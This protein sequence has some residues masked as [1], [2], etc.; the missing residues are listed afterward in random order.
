MAKRRRDYAKETAYES[1]P[2]QKK[3]RAERNHD[4]RAAERAGLVHKG[5]G[6][7]VDHLGSHRTGNLKGVPTKV[8]SKHANRIR[9]PKRS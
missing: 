2:L 5:D 1:T 7:E 8:V 3:R 9:Q 4:R 6:K